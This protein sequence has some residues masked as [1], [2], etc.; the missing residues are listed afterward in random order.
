MAWIEMA[1]DPVHGGGS[2]SF[3]ECLWSPTEI[4]D[5]SRTW[6]YWSA[7]RDVQPGDS[8][9]HLRG[10]QP[11]ASFVGTSI[12]ETPAEQTLERPPEPGEW[13]WSDA[14]F[15]VFLRDFEPFTTP[16]PLTHVF[17]SRSEELIAYHRRHSPLKAPGGKLLFYVPQ[18]GRL[19]CQNGAYLSE[20]DD[21]LAEILFGLSVERPG[22]NPE[23]I[24]LDVNTAEQ[25]RNVKARIGQQAFSNNV[26]DNYEG[27][28]CFPG[29]AVNDRAFLIGSHIAR[30]A[31]APELRGLVTNGLALCLLHDRAFERGLFTLSL[32]HR[33]CFN[34]AR[35]NASP[36]A[37]SY[38]TG[39]AE[40]IRLGQVQPSQ[41]A[42]ELHWKRIKFRPD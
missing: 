27:K 37:I 36:W 11:N 35:I 34:R 39:E 19:Q 8:I 13:A 30:W 18:A 28:C 38:L 31:D 24:T 29:C 3:G 16:I 14:F 1:R 15:R 21:E 32:D 23:P 10:R 7:L 12:A 22:R 26:K 17:E 40:Q 4:R 33:I 41:A 2:W 25:L 42:I 5:G 9:V 6:A 20:L